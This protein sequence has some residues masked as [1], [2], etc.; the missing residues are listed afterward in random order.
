MEACN[1]TQIGSPR[2][3]LVPPYRTARSDACPRADRSTLG[4]YTRVSTGKAPSGVLIGG[5]N[6]PDSPTVLRPEPGDWRHSPAVGQSV[7]TTGRSDA[8][9]GGDPPADQHSLLGKPGN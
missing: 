7:T 8:V 4:D 2:G 9:C 5:S 1:K 6:G 3:E